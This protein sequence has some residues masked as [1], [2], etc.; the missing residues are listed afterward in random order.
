MP[1][2]DPIAQR[3]AVRVVYD[4]VA[5][6]GKTTNL[7]QLSTLFAARRR[8]ALHSPADLRGRTL[9]FD[10]MQV[11]AGVVCGFPLLCQVLSVPGQ[12]VLTPRR[13][14]LLPRGETVPTPARSVIRAARLTG[15]PEGTLR[16]RR[17]A[18]ARDSRCCGT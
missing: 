12:V 9:F 14:R 6:A 15:R 17:R 7:R 10:W 4:G 11:E 2:Y 18:S 13:R 8:E 3:M 5:C 16:C 1:I